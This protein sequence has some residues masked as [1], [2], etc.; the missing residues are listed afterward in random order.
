MDTLIKSPARVSTHVSCSLPKAV[1]GGGVLGAGQGQLH[2]EEEEVRLQGRGAGSRVGPGQGSAPAGGE[3]RSGEVMGR[4]CEE[5]AQQVGT[6]LSLGQK[7][8]KLSTGRS[9]LGGGGRRRALMVAPRALWGHQLFFPDPLALKLLSS[10]PCYVA[11]PLETK[12]VIFFRASFP[13]NLRRYQSCCFHGNLPR[14]PGEGGAGQPSRP[15]PPSPPHRPCSSL[16]GGPKVK[17]IPLPQIF[18]AGG[19]STSSTR[20]GSCFCL[21]AQA[22]I[23]GP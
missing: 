8:Q 12:M 5:A 10:P 1:M 14:Q 3:G 17:I 23:W 9:G 18:S 16:Q 6:G 20:E 22:E 21:W 7:M 11:F 13:P 15:Q 19:G 4:Q 2:C